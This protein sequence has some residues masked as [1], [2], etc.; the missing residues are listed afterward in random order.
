MNIK[1]SV[2]FLSLAGLLVVGLFLWQNA[3]ERVAAGY[4]AFSFFATGV[5][6]AFNAPKFWLKQ[7]NGKIHPVSFLLL[8]PMHILNW[9][10]LWLAIRLQ[11]E[12]AYHE[13]R[14]GLWLGRRLLGREAEFFISNHAA[15]VD[16]TSEFSENS[17]LLA[18]PYLCLPLLDRTAPDVKQLEE[19][20]F[21]IGRHLPERPVFV[22]CAVGHGRS[23]TVVAAWLLRQDRTPDV[24]AV[25]QEIRTIRPGVNLHREQSSVLQK[26]I[27]NG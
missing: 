24:N 27:H 26:L 10:S 25:I 17:A 8:A 6:Y 23:A 13:I 14:P 9:V 1:F 21:F 4:I 3:V 5:A 22:H 11:K 15:V 19:A 7:P 16:M 2:I 12:P 18:N 20:I